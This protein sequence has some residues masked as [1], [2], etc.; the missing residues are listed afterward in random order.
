MKFRSLPLPLT[1]AAIL[2]A[3]ACGPATTS[4]TRYDCT[5]GSSGVGI[6]TQFD[7]AGIFS[8]NGG[9]ANG[10]TGV[11]T[12]I[13]APVIAEPPNH[14]DF[15]VDIEGTQATLLPPMVVSS[16]GSAGWLSLTTDFDSIT[17]APTIGY[18]DSTPLPI[19]PGSVFM[20][21]AVTAG[22]SLLPYTTQHYVYSKFIID[23]V[24]YYPYNALSAPDGLT[25]YYHMVSDPICGYTSFQAGIPPH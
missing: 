25:V 11:N 15:A 19:A 5:T 12:C 4:S 21:Q 17:D 10:P 20:I 22:C 6:T 24:H 1:A 9:P 7:T 14:F 8:L 23:S 13:P 3:M 18:N 16:A 2:L